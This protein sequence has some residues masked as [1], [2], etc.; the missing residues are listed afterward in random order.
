VPA[1]DKTLKQHRPVTG[2]AARLVPVILRVVVAQ[3]RLDPLEALVG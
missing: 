3:H 2:D 1:P